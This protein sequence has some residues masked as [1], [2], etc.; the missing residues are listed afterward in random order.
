MGKDVLVSIAVCTYNGE[1]FLKQQLDTLAEQTYRNI[2]II[3][4]D[5]K[6]TDDTCSIL[7]EYKQKDSRIKVYLNSENLGYNRNFEKAIKLCSGELIAICDQDDL[8]HK[9]KLETLLSQLEEDTML[10]HHS[11]SV[12]SDENSLP[13]LKVIQ[14]AGGFYGSDLKAI[15]LGNTVQGCTI[16]MRKELKE[17]IFPFDKDVIYDWWLGVCAANYGKVQ[18]LH[19]NL[20]W[21]RRHEQSA[22]YSVESLKEKQEHY[23]KTLTALNFFQK[24]LKLN[25]RNERFL[26]RFISYQSKLLNIKFSFGAFVFFIKHASH[27]YQ[28]K[29]KSFP[30]FSILSFSIRSARGLKYFS[31]H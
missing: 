24:F 10:I 20:M 3:I 29:N 17:F 13:E 25:K 6:S 12:F 27:F 9:T 11:V 15:L 22:H 30:Y 8:W 14:R 28:F 7:E 1:L 19:Q 2:E 16:M 21:H 18:Y 26:E 23:K 31:S 5:D 4:V